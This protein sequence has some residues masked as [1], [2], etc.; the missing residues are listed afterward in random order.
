[1]TRRHAVCRSFESRLPN[2]EGRGGFDMGDALHE[3]LRASPTWVLVGEV[4]GGYV[5]H[6]LEAATVGHRLGDVHD[7]C[8][9]GRRACSRRS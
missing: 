9:L 7:P 4:R 2:A 1:M 3:A 5:V 6:L 8:P